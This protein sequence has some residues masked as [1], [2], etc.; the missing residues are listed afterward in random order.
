MLLR[1]YSYSNSY[2]LLV[3]MQNGTATL[4]DILAVFLKTNILLSYNPA[5]VLLGI[6]PKELKTQVH[7]EIF[8]WMF[9]AALFR[10]VK[11][12]K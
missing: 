2:W 10:I 9:I 1:M 5:I 11:T 3:G 12:W 6:Y 8:R 7:T 4:E